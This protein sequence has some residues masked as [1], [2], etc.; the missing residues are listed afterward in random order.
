[1]G[2]FDDINRAIDSTIGTNLSGNNSSG[3]AASL[4]SQ[5]SSQLESMRRGDVGGIV[6]KVAG[7]TGRVIMSPLLIAEDVSRGDIQKAGNT[8]GKTAGSMSN[9]ALQQNY[10]SDTGAGRTVLTNN[11]V[12]KLTLGYSSDAY[13]VSRA[14]RTL[15]DSA[16][17]SDADR[18]SSIRWGVKTAAIAS[19]AKAYDYLT[20]D[21]PASPSGATTASKSFW[22]DW[23]SSQWVTN[24]TLAA[25][26]VTSLSKGDVKGAVNQY[27]NAGNE[28]PLPDFLTPYLPDGGSNNSSPSYGRGPGSVWTSSPAS[29]SSGFS[30]GQTDQSSSVTPLLAIAAVV[31]AAYLIKKSRAA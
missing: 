5:F 30:E 8:V 4:Q 29:S 23:T 17:V 3:W 6:S 18:N 2:F 24:T 21:S 16:Y 19:G 20:S 11:T 31:G 22:S 14:G 26:V 1:M 25:G 28:S 13:G 15:A 7:D 10:F 9:L 12:D 27:V